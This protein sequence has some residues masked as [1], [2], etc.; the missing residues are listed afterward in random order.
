V[1]DYKFGQKESKYHLAQVKEYMDLI[2]QMG[3][4]TKGYVCYAE[5]GK[6]VEVFQN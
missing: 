3:Y 5:L 2:A 4:Q 1:I 6:V